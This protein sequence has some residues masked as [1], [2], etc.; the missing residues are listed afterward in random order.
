MWPRISELLL[1]LWLLV[2]PGVL[3]G[4]A[5][6]AVAGRMLAVVVLI[7]SAASFAPRFRRAH[8]VTL[9]ASLGMTAVP[10]FH[11]HPA[12]PLLQG[13]MITGLVIAMFAV[14]PV[15]AMKPPPGWLE[16]E[17]AMEKQEPFEGP[18]G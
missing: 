11:A 14:I 10:F 3:E 1:A 18:K 12:P 16:F 17:D 2:A 5:W 15:G 13:V 7:A 9:L 4:P 6:G 8:L